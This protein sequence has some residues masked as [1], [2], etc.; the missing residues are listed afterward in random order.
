[1]C[2]IGY[3]SVYQ[4]EKK[5]EKRKSRSKSIHNIPGSWYEELGA[6]LLARDITAWQK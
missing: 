5:K 1:M 3:L 2:R 6:L 4:S